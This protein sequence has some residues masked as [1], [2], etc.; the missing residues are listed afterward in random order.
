MKRKILFS[1]LGIIFICIALV[2]INPGGIFTMTMVRLLGEYKSPEFESNESII[3]FTDKH[4]V[5]YDR[6]FRV[7]TLKNFYNLQNLKLISIPT[8][9]IFDQDKKLLTSASG[10]DC[11]NAMASFFKQGDLSK[12]AAK[13]T[14]L[15]DV[16]LNE[17]E[18]VDQKNEPVD[19]EYYFLAGW[20]KFGPDNTINLFDDIKDI[21]S[22]NKNIAFY[23]INF[24][25]RPEWESQMD[26][27][28][29]LE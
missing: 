9:Y 3:Q 16:I 25:F 17:L 8:I 13:D 28:G 20:A 21:K 29:L 1:V 11:D 12:F 15:F 26:S 4:E 22:L 27:L 5:Y 23:N 2:I 18:M 7:A 14:N 6:L 10:D 19:A 24:D